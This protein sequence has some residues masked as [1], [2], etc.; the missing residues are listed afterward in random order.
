MSNIRLKTDK[1]FEEL[2]NEQLRQIVGGSL[3][4]D[5]LNS[6]NLINNA[7]LLGAKSGV[8]DNEGVSVSVSVVEGQR[9]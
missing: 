5:T 6:A 7:N 2:S 3:V 4:A 1:F 8:T 9:R